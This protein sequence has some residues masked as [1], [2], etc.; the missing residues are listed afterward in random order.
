M[1]NLLGYESKL[2]QVLPE[3]VDP[4]S[5]A[6]LGNKSSHVGEGKV[7]RGED[8]NIKLA[9][10]ITQ[11]LPNGNMVISGSQE[12]LVNFEKRILKI[13]GVIRP[14]DISVDNTI[15]HDQIAEARIVY[16]GEGQLSDVQQPR[17]GQQLYD[18]LFPF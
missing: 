8:I 1:T 10:V 5:I 11:I 16:G 17:Y 6:S 9:A 2:G 4:S 7:E 14:Q 15:N 12:I 18:I 3:A 13:A